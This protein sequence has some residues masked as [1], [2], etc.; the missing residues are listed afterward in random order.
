M[1]SSFLESATTTSCGVVLSF[2]SLSPSLLFFATF[3]QSFLQH[4]IIL[5]IV[6]L[7]W[8]S[9]CDRWYSGGGGG[10]DGGREET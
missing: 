6:I 3:T 2:L 1:V 9:G 4:T 7:S 10:R 5:I 8:Y